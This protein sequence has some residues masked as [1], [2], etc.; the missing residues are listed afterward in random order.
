MTLEEVEE[1]T[2]LAMRKLAS[3]VTVVT[4]RDDAARQA[5]TAT[6]V[7]S[8]SMEPPSLLVCINKNAALYPLLLAKHPFAVNILSRAQ[9]DVSANC[10][11]AKQGEDRFSDGVW[12]THPDGPPILLGAQANIICDTDGFLDYGSH[13]IF[14]GK[15]IDIKLEEGLDPLIYV[16]GGYTSTCD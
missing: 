13:G 8:L 14:V 9:E 11:G 3:S 6:S 12:D 2:R 16:D 7:T 10:G 15:V 4:S 5:M 1:L